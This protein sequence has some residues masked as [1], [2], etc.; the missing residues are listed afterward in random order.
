MRN[1]NILSL[2]DMDTADDIVPMGHHVVETAIVR[3]PVIRSIL[4]LMVRMHPAREEID[5][6]HEVTMDTIRGDIET[7]V[8]IG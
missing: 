5:I 7:V 8:K 6:V 2:I 1:L 3:L 4:K